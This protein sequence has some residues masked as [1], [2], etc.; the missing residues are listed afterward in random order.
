MKRKIKTAILI[1]GRGSN[2][3][4]LIK[5]SLDSDFPA[6]IVLV[7]S[8]KA[9]AA[10]L[11]FAEQNNIATAVI[12]HKKFANRQDFDQKIDEVLQSHQVEL[13]CL[14]GFMRILSPQL[15]KKWHKKMINIHPSLLPNFKGANAVLDALN[16]QAKITGCTTHFVSEEVDAGEII[17]Q[18][19]V[20]IATDD[21][22]ASLSAKILDQEH[23]IYPR[24][25]KI[26]CENLL[27]KI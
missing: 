8:N 10:G 2:M 13:V 9:D 4:A 3:Q 16:A 12:D 6:Q 26:V 27:K 18:S 25:L 7:L 19:Q 1:S 22:L 21:N 14:A 20:T 11:K 17:L 24:S 5:A 15:V 23:I